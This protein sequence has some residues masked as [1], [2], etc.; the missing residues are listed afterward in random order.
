MRHALYFA[1]AALIGAA[2]SA[3]EL[4]DAKAALEKVGV[5]VSATGVALA[6]E[7]EL[8]KELAKSALLKRNVLQA[9]KELQFTEQQLDGLQKAMAQM[10]QQHLQLSAQLVNV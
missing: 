6:K 3:D 1:A 8:N 9:Q 7:G 10:K 5:R 4:A 2:A